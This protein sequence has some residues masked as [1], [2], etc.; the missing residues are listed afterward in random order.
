MI[1]KESSKSNKTNGIDQILDL[2]CH[3]QTIPEI[4]D[5]P[6]DTQCKF[7]YFESHM[8]VESKVHFQEHADQFPFKSCCLLNPELGLKFQRT[9]LS[10][11]HLILYCTTLDKANWK[12]S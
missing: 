12:A 6:T 11:V 3:Q 10:L 9:L 2:L 4:Q 5:H 7:V 8:Y 1:N